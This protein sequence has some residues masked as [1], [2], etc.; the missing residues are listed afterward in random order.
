MRYFPRKP[1]KLKL[2][3]RK[4]HKNSRT[5]WESENNTKNV[6]LIAWFCKLLCTTCHYSSTLNENDTKWTQKKKKKYYRIDNCNCLMYRCVDEQRKRI[7]K[8]KNGIKLKWMA[9][10]NVRHIC[11]MTIYIPKVSQFVLRIFR[12]ANNWRSKINKIR[13][14]FT[15]MIEIGW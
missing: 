7:W 11:K 14:Q 13:T 8:R 1:L 5:V 4:A 9:G 2:N 10:A 15:E 12:N 3:I 6:V